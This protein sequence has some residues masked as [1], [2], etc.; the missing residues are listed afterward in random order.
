MNRL[1][2]D[3]WFGYNTLS[4]VFDYLNDEDL[5]NVSKVCK[6]WRDVTSDKLKYRAPIFTCC[7]HLEEI[8]GQYGDVICKLCV[9]DTHHLSF[10]VC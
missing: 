7:K 10:K 4:L 3:I 1:S 6:L 2:D 9:I 5:L 8:G